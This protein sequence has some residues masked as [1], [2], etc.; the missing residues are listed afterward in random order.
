MLL[1]EVSSMKSHILQIYIVNHVNF[2]LVP[3]DVVVVVIYMHTSEIIVYFITSFLLSI[4]KNGKSERENII[5]SIFALVRF[6]SVREWSTYTMRMVLVKP[7]PCFQP[8]TTM[9]VSP[10][11]MNPRALPKRTPNCTRSSTS[12][13]QSFCAGSAAENRNKLIVNIWHTHWH[14]ECQNKCLLWQQ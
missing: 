12:F 5:I 14:C 8:V 6:E 4:A 1:F 13:I 11:L 10:V 9:I 7:E 2:G 3:F